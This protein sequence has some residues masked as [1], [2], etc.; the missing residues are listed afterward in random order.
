MFF[1]QELIDDRNG[2]SILHRDGIQ[3]AV[4]N[5]ETPRAVQLLDEEYQGGEGGVAAPHDAL[6]YHSRALPFQLILVRGS[7]AIWPNCHGGRAGLESDV[8]CAPPGRRQT[9]RCREDVLEGVQQ[10]IE[11]GLGHWS[12]R[13]KAGSLRRCSAAPTYVPP[14]MLEGHG[15]C[16]DVLDDV[17]QWGHPVGAED[18]II[19]RQGHDVEVDAEFQPIDDDRRLTKDARARDALPVGHCGC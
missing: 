12:G 11:K 18:D 9:G 19:A 3:R 1:I 16:R 2:V 15:A 17:P 13:M 4:V 5:A 14:H 7:I 8:V 10:L 6:L